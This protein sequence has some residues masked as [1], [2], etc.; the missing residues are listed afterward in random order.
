MN[1]IE[2]EN[3]LNSFDSQE[4]KSA[5]CEVRK[6][7]DAGELSVKEDT[8]AHNL[9]CH[10]IFSYNGYGY[11]PSY[12]AYLAKK[13]GWF[14]AGIVDFDVLDG[15]DEFLDACRI[16]GVRGVCG[17]ETRA[18]LPEFSTREINSPGEPGITYHMGIGFTQKNISGDTEKAAAF[19]RS[20]K[21]S[22][23][24]R[25]RDMVNKVNSF[26]SPVELDFDQDAVPLTPDGNVTERH[27]CQSYEIKAKK[28][29]PDSAKL[30][31]FWAEKLG[32]SK[33]DAALMIGDSVKLQGQ[34]RSKTMKSGGVGY[35]K[36]TAESFPL[37][38][39]VNEFI[40]AA[41]GIPTI[42]WLN[43]LS[44]GEQAIEELLDLQ[45]ELGGAVLNIVP[46]RNWNVSDPEDKSAKLAELAKIVKICE[47]RNLPV[48]VGT[49]MNAPGLKLVDTFDS[50]ELE[51][52]TQIFK[53]GAAIIYAHTVL[54]PEG[55]GYLSDW[56]K[57]KFANI[58]EK[59]AYF[60]EIGFGDLV[61]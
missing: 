21:Q 55:K 26:L 54:Q 30:V 27:V 51:S 34:I 38:K 42:T 2:V 8:D 9:H 58:A 50:E 40:L 23:Q 7:I 32:V 33:E 25:T 35:V 47:L 52:Y 41:G 43:G 53:K 16:L 18:Y 4:R 28:I 5:V 13:E 24:D 29:F 60:A 39:D 17:L 6:L 11:S 61:I 57:S 10:T 45:Q 14:A 22:A 44:D 20:M 31:E 1:I 12:I 56:A 46:D 15:V 3:Q 36:P 19:L 59:N 48:I 49:E 37:V